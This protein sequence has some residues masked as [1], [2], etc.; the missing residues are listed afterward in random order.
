VEINLSRIPALGKGFKRA[1]AAYR[2]TEIT[3][4]TDQIWIIRQV[5]FD[6]SLVHGRRGRTLT[7]TKRDLVQAF[8]KKLTKEKE[9]ENQSINKKVP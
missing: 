9:N 2:K 1:R 4:E 8:P 6:A 5:A 7:A 3:L